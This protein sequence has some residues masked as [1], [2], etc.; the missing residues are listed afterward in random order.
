MNRY[1]KYTYDLMMEDEKLIADM[2]C[3]TLDRIRSLKKNGKTMRLR[4]AGELHVNLAKMRAGGYAVQNF[5]VFVDLREVADPFEDA[6]EQ[7]ELFEKEMR[8]NSDWISPVTTGKEID[9]NIREGKLS[10]LL[11]LEEG[12]ICNGEV[13]KLEELYRRGAR[14]MTL[15]WNYENILAS[16]ALLIREEDT[17]E[18]ESFLPDLIQP[19]LKK[20][21][22]LIVEAMEALGMIP[23]VSHLSD[24]GFYDVCNIC[25]KPFVASHSNAR[26][27][28][29]HARNLSDDM[30]RQLGE[31][32]GVAGLNYFPEF[33]LDVC[34]HTE[35]FPEKNQTQNAAVQETL[36]TTLAQHARHMVNCG[37]REC[38]GLGSDFD[39]FDGV[40]APEG[41]DHAGDMAWALHRVG[42]SDAE[43]DNIMYRNVLKLYRE[44]LG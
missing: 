11:T 22:F 1:N 26:A 27:I 13:E 44:V 34:D 38:V 31:H 40:C 9:K 37:G 17:G 41:A 20:E 39:G 16:P 36:L 3:D 2:H 8:E 5:A 4:D 24:A 30:L 21:G 6:L 19:G 42:F 43:V 23:D 25:R 14:M 12:A 28:C 35:W 15:C 7:T 29:R 33:I 32:G 10:A 18:A